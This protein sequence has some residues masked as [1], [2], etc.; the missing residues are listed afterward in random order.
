[1]SI[2]WRSV[3]LYAAWV[4]GLVMMSLPLTAQSLF[5]GIGS[6]PDMTTWAI[7]FV[8]GATF[9]VI[10]YVV[11]RWMQAMDKLAESVERLAKESIKSREWKRAVDKDLGIKK[12]WLNQ[13]RDWIH[14]HI[15]VHASCSECPEINDLHI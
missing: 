15:R 1:M 14:K 7:M 6:D 4:I 8:A 13:H 12:K 10:M 3:V 9:T 5:P 11:K 2:K